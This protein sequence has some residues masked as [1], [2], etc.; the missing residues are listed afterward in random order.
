M[1]ILNLG[2][3]KSEFHCI[4]GDKGNGCNYENGTFKYSYLL[5][6]YHVCFHRPRLRNK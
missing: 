5:L 4:L 3:L 2:G 1:E 6:L